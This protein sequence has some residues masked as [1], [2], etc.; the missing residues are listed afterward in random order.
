MGKNNHKGFHNFVQNLIRGKD[1][2]PPKKPS[3]TPQTDLP[4]PKQEPPVAPKSDADLLKMLS[5][6]VDAAPKDS[7]TPSGQN[8]VKKAGL[9]YDNGALQQHQVNTLN[10]LQAMKDK[11]KPKFGYSRSEAP[12]S[13]AK[14]ALSKK[15]ISKSEQDRLIDK[16][17]E[18]LQKRKDKV[19]E[20]KTE[21][22]AQRRASPRRRSTS[23]SA[24]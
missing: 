18:K 11:A 9:G 17:K 15:A 5:G 2:K 24:T 1:D 7:T 8:R 23:R 3:A 10:A 19:R 4:K 6:G 14:A 22:E 16:R 20:N 12:E 13:V 21:Q